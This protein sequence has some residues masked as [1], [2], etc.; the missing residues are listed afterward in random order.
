MLSEEFRLAWPLAVEAALAS[1]RVDD[2][3]AQLALVSHT[4]K[5]HVPPYLRAQ[6]SR[7]RGLVASARGDA[8]TAEGDLRSSIE[9]FVELG[10]TSWL[11]RSRVDLAGCLAVLGRTS[12]V[13]PLLRDAATTF[14]EL[15][16][17]PDLEHVQDVLRDVEPP[18]RAK[19]PAPPGR[20]VVR[21]NRAS[22]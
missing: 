15:R 13:E 14:T 9:Q 11:A 22:R 19:E 7:L 18:D 12:E 10:Y 20:E 17:Q 4:P 21:Q 3:T 1:G 2:A 8:A 5:G 16:A 6:L